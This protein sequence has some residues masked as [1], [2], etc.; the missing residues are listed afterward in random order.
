MATRIGGVFADFLANTVDFQRNVQA[1][2]RSLRSSAAGMN[3]SLSSIESGF[4]T[5]Q[6]VAGL[7]GAA[8]G[9]GALINLGR[10]ALE[11]SGNLLDVADKIG[12]TTDALQKLRFAAEQ[13]G[14]A[15]SALDMGLQRFSRRVGEAAQ[16]SGELVKTL[17]Q[18]GIAVTDSNG[19][20]RSNLDILRDY[21]DVIQ[22][23][24]SEQEKLRLAFKAFDSEGSALVN[25]LK[26]GSAGLD[27]LMQRAADMGVVVDRDLIQ[28]AADADDALVALG[29]Q[30]SA[31]AK[32]IVA[33]AAPAIIEF[34]DAL[35]KLSAFVFPTPEEKL[36][37]TLNRLYDLRVATKEWTSA[38][39]DQ[40]ERARALLETY[41]DLNAQV[42][43]RTHYPTA[44]GMEPPRQRSDGLPPPGDDKGADQIQKVIDKLKFETDQLYRSAEAQELYNNLKAAGVAL[45]S[46][47]GQKIAAMTATLQ[48]E[49]TAMAAAEEATKKADAAL[50][51]LKEEGQRLAEE[52]ATPMETYQAQLVRINELLTAGAIGQEVYNRKVV[53]LQDELAR[54]NPLVRGLEDASKDFGTAIGTAFEDAIIQGRSFS[55]VLQALLQD[56]Q[57]ILLRAMVTKP[58]EGLVGTVLKGVVGGLAGGATGTGGFAFAGDV[59]VPSG[60]NF[61]HF[62]E[63]GRPPLGRWSIVGERG[64]ELFKPDV[65]GTIIP[66][67][68]LA[69]MGGGGPVFHVDM[70][71]ASVEAVQRLERF[72]Q[73]VNGS[74]ER[75]AI[76]AVFEEQRRNGRQR[77][78]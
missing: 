13:S 4:R 72:V 29:A 78:V 7:F 70:R 2:Q 26:D 16:G 58:L 61:S 32:V 68:E 40:L 57:R 31:T 20:M 38:T 33:Q 75:R 65:A 3:K 27:T 8:L 47:A 49:K 45:N 53:Q 48:G 6:R 74:I 73:Q 5:V 50:Q 55:E 36:Q 15:Q 43:A 42:I 59:H 10:H 21:A 60:V 1:A 22:R 71:G 69:G 52:T 17:R 46:E 64:P 51:K 19:R 76:G 12:F 14:V 24:P 18:Y 23:A 35:R 37:Q 25:T 41:H 44:A 63:G 54:A 11:A 30:I 62:A 39:E 56:L 67:H 9:V 66:N 28:K 34:A 77:I